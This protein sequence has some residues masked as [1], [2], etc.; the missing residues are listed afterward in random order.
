M[1]IDRQY[2]RIMERI[3]V[4]LDASPRA[5]AVR[6]AAVDLARRLGGSLLVAHAY[7]LPVGLP[8]EA[9]STALDALPAVLEN[10][11]RQTLEELSAPIPP[12][13]L[14]GKRLLLGTPWQQICEAARAEKVDLIVI[15]SHGYGGLDRLLGT[16]AGRIVNHAHCSVLVVHD[17]SWLGR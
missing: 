16:T 5:P 17:P 3:L 15:G 14:A 13:L 8:L 4:A 10:S 9:Y 6:D 12:E 2:N 11:A 7:S 1:T